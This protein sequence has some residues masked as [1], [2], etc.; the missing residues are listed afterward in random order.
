MSRRTCASDG[1]ANRFDG[2]ANRVYC[3]KTCRDRE[4]KRRHREKS[5]AEVVEPKRIRRG[6]VYATLE[7]SPRLVAALDAGDISQIEAARAIGVSK[8]AFSEAWATWL[9]ERHQIAAS[10]TWVMDP[11]VEGWYA[12]DEVGDDIEGWLDRAVAGFVAWRAAMFLAPNGKPYL[13]KLFHRVWIRQVLKAIV[14]GGRHMILSPPR[15][16]KSELLIHFVVW[17]I[18]RDPH[19]RAIWIGPNQDIAEDM[20]GMVK[21]ILEDNEKLRAATL[22]PG[23]AWQPAGRNKTAWGVKKLTVAN[24]TRALKAPTLRAVG[25]GQKI[26]SMDVDLIIC[27]DIEDFDST[28]NEKSRSDTRNWMFNNV[29]S[30]KEEHTA[31]LVIGSRQHPDD[32]YDYI[33]ADDEWSTQVD[34]A[35]DPKCIKPSDEYQAHVSCMLF[36]E[37]RTYLWLMGK[38]RTAENQ[39]LLANYEMVYLNDPRPVGLTVFRQESIDACKNH[40]RGLGL[41]GMRDAVA[42]ITG[43][44]RMDVNYHLIGGLDPSATGYQAAFL[45]A[46][47]A[48]LNKIYAIDASNRKGGGI[49]PF[50]ELIVE[51]NEAYQLKHWLWENNILPESDLLSNPDV[52]AY[53][54]A[55]DIYLEPHNTQ[56]G[57]KNDPFFG[58]GAMHYDYD[59]HNIDLPWGTEGAREIMKV[60]ER[61]MIRFVDSANTLRR[62]NRKTD[63]LMSSWFPMKAIRRFRKERMATVSVAPELEYVGFDSV[64]W[65]EVPW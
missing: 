60:Y 6:D 3:S 34:S 52:R 20:V 13:T 4:N 19:F 50:L 23:V 48:E 43:K 2:H 12:L 8:S 63:L 14:T 26:L 58:V 42:A 9:F 32:L 24:R 17:M 29:E 11:E 28:I 41:E 22:P 47:V 59:E 44:D 45:W 30:R 61:Q 56:G 62:R 31:W 33:L 10:E 18:A 25:R 57:N 5:R 65:N 21:T 64:D 54:D 36:P 39:G 53:C 46:Y 35:H 40:A 1:C 7:N 38:R 16:G 51:W 49:Y 37:V 15:H 55:N 27:D